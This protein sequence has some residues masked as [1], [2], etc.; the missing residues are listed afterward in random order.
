[1]YKVFINDLPLFL[2]GPETEPVGETVLCMR[3]DGE[4][5]ML[6]LIGLA[7]KCAENLNA[8]YLIHHD[9][10][11]LFKAFSALYRVQEAAGGR[12][13]HHANRSVLMIFRRGRWDLPK[14]KIDKGESP[15]EAALREVEEECGVR[16]LTIIRPLP[17]TWHTF[18][19]K[20]QRILK[21][22]HWFEMRCEEEQLTPQREEDIEQALWADAAQQ[23]AL[24]ADTYPSLLEV[25]DA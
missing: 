10:E 3:Y 18:F 23:R 19:Q 12:V 6:Q 25:L 4:S 14:G 9:I 21:C 20:Q 15:E 13:H 5:T 1:M 16:L 7:E 11:E 17:K 24:R 8:V 2:A 22:T